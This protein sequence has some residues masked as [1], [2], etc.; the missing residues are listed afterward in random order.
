MASVSIIISFYERLTHLKCC[1]DS[2]IHC[3]GDFAEVI[4]AD[5]GSSQPTVEAL[6]AI[7]PTYPFPIVHAWQPKDG[8][9]LS[10]SRNNGI[11][12][13]S[14]SYLIFLDC[15]FAVL[16]GAI[17][18]HLE[19]AR[20]GRFLAGLCKYLPEEPTRGLMGQSIT[21]KALENLYAMLP[22]HPISREHWKFF[23]YSLLIRLHLASARKQRCSSH[24]SIHRQD[25]E[26]INGYDENFVGWGGEDEDISLRMV[27]AGFMG[28]P[29]INNARVLHLWHPQELGGKHWREGANIDYLYRKG[30]PAFCEKGLTQKPSPPR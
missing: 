11:R 2:L 8:F 25:L 19:H 17:R 12:K 7:I 15:D 24:F 1:L 22:E 10:A 18:S 30:I 23:R 5:D 26:A 13:S 9:R 27:R 3:A 28:Y 14:G 16:P 6:K 29:V 21:P 4:I 20:P